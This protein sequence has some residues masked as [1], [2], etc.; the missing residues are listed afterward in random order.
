MEEFKGSLIKFLTEDNL[1]LE[2]FLQEVDGAKTAMIFVH[3]M[4]SFFWKSTEIKVLKTCEEARLPC[5]VI[6]TRGKGGMNSFK[7]EKE[8]GDKE[9][10]IA[11]TS[12]EVFEDCIKDIEAAKTALKEKGYTKFIL[13]GHST[14]CQK[15]L[16]YML[17]KKDAEV[18]ALVLLGPGDD[19]N[20]FKQELGDD[21][22]TALDSAKEKYETEVIDTNEAFGLFSPRR[23]Y[24]LLKEDSIEGNLFNYETDLAQLKEITIPVF[25]AFGKEDETA[26]GGSEKAL[27]KIKAQLANKDS[28]TV[29]TPG[30]HGFKGGEEELKK[31]MIAWITQINK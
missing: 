22:Q 21:F 30:D 5:F 31:E 13:G 17:E 4:V 14:G 8:G 6:N 28:K 15:V 27:E 10:L 7:I 11:G 25:A 1:Q 16:H 20:M 23:F 9:Y 24:D 18:S 29:E 3:G 19:M 2:G 12:F 26:F